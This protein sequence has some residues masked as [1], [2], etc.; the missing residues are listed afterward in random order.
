MEMRQIRAPEFLETER[1]IADNIEKMSSEI[2][3][4]QQALSINNTLLKSTNDLLL[5]ITDFLRTLESQS[6]FWTEE[7]QKGEREATKD[8]ETGAIHT[9]EDLEQLIDFL[10]S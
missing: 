5:Q 10:D 3:S 9:F 8:I 1:D 7:W 4:L 6:Y 2:A